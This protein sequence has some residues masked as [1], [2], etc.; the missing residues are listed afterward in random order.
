MRQFIEPNLRECR[1]RPPGCRHIFVVAHGIFN[2]E[3]IGALLARRK[4]SQPLEWGYKGVSSRSRVYYSTICS[5]YDS[6]GMTNVSL[7][8]LTHLQT[9]VDDL[10]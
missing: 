2:A 9:A 8:L 10:G 7:L 1:G 4:D 6:P 5:W 3:F